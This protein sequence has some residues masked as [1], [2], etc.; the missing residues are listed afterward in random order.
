[1]GGLYFGGVDIRHWLLLS[2]LLLFNVTILGCLF[3]LITGK[4]AP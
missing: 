2:I 3:L 1:M 4:I